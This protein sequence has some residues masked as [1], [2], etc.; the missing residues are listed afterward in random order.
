MRDLGPLLIAATIGLASAA[1]AAGAGTLQVSPTRI[2]LAARQQSGLLTLTNTGAEAVRIEVTAFTWDQSADGQIVLGETNDLVVFPTLFALAPG[3]TRR[4]KM[5]VTAAAGARE[6]SYRVIV[7]ELP[8]PTADISEVRVLTHMSIPVFQA[9]RTTAR[10]G[11]IDGVAL[12]G[13]RLTLSV[14]N[15]GTVHVML[16]SAQI[17]GKDAAGR[18]I[19]N[20]QAPGWY[21]LAGGRRAFDLAVPADVE[22]RIASVEIEAITDDNT[23]SQVVLLAGSARHE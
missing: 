8:P 6:R 21:L 15:R 7:A 23:W 20:G 4:V 10:A 2:D 3:E 5:G 18:T 1:S 14:E 11:G 12:A 9:P 22:A 17:A 16:K 13:G 19:W